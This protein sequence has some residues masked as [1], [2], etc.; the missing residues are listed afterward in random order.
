MLHP[1]RLILIL[2]V[3]SGLAAAAMALPMGSTQTSVSCQALGGPGSAETNPSAIA[4]CND[5]GTT[6]VGSTILSTSAAASALKLGLSSV[7]NAQVTNGGTTGAGISHTLFAEVVA[8]QPTPV[9]LTSIPLLWDASFEFSS[10][11]TAGDSTSGQVSLTVLRFTLGG[12]SAGSGQDALSFT[13][14]NPPGRSALSAAFEYF[15]DSGFRPELQLSFGNSCSTIAP[16]G[17]TSSCMLALHA[18][19]L[20]FDQQAFDLRMGPN[21]F[22]LDQYFTILLPEPGIADL[23]VAGIAGLTLAGSRRWTAR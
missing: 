10:V 19:P 5:A 1:C 12:G 2:T 8:A 13:A 17:I 16:G 7:A 4:G 18:L 11:S 20:R 22:Q 14:Q 9:P 15:F 3:S 6:V 23:L 21:T